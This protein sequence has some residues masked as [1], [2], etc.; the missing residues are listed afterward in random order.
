MDPGS[1]IN[2]VR[3]GPPESDKVIEE[4]YCNAELRANTRK[5]V[6]SKGGSRKEADTVYT[7]VILIFVKNCH[8]PD[9][10]IRSNLEN[11]FFGVTKNLWARTLRERKKNRST[12]LL[13]PLA[14]PDDPESLLLKS[15]TRTYARKLL[16][17]LDDKC[18]K[19]LL[20]WMY[21]MKMKAIA[22]KMDY[23][24]A[25]VARKKKHLCLKKLI[26]LTKDDPE[27]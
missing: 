3:Q 11:Y 17:K 12:D 6:M 20:L 22:A 10:N 19:V 21:G 13:P 25:E 8:K 16:L 23:S 26:N 18:Q 27:L 14:D 24:S 4:L 7:D 1:L 9:F 2:R 5:Y 15:E